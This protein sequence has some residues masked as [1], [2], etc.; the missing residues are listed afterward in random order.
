MWS[1]SLLAAE[2]S[3]LL[4]LLAWGAGSAIVGSLLLV[5]LIVATRRGAAGASA[6]GVAAGEASPLLLHF[7][8]QTAA[9]GAIDLVIAALAWRGLAM[10]DV[11]GATRLDR[12]LWLNAGLDVGYVAVGVTL[13]AAGWIIGRRLG[14]VGAGLGI[15]VQGAALLV[16]DAKFIAVIAALAA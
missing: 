11:D 7:A 14:A 6:A 10:R 12:L 1:D 5:A 9:W 8:I 4:R 3:H 15:V 13:A 2:R 16:L